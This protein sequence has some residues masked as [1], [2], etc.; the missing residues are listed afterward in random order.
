MD[1]VFDKLEGMR[2][3]LTEKENTTKAVAN[4]L[5]RK[6]IDDFETKTREFSQFKFAVT[7]PLN[8]PKLR[9]S[10]VTLASL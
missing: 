6:E 4:G 5:R 8:S 7:R 10:V 2:E 1:D 9:I 3:R